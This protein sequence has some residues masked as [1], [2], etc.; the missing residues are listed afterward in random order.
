MFCGKCGSENPDDARFCGSCGAAIN[1]AM[2]PPPADFRPEVTRLLDL[3]TPQGTVS[4]GLK[5]GI[6]GASLLV[7]L[8]GIG[9]GL[10]YWIKGGSEEK[11]AVG[12]LWFFV[13]LGLAA[14]YGVLMGEGY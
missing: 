5:W 8:V 14:L 4:P 13:A 11:T 2:P 1:A 12:R 9:M 3:D 6:L 7:P 10:Y